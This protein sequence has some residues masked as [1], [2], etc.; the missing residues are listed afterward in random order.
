[1][2]ITSDLSTRYAFTLMA[3]DTACVHTY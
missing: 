2:L 1:M 3:A